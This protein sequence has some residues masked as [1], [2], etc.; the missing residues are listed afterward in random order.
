MSQGDTIESLELVK[1]VIALP[2][3]FLVVTIEH[4]AL[5]SVQ[6]DWDRCDCRWLMANLIF[7]VL[8]G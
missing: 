5:E 2:H 3:Q 1:L 8:V 6:L 7:G 4:A